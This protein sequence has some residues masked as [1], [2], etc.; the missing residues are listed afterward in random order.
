MTTDE[1][2]ESL[3]DRLRSVEFRDRLA[4]HEFE[5]RLELFGLL[6]GGFLVVVG[7]ATVAGTPWTHKAS[8]GAS[9][10]Q[11]VGA[12]GT[13]AVGAGLVWLTQTWTGR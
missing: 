3:P 8:L 4:D 9:I 13:A 1:A 10:L 2:K 5:D 7:L 6:A 12:L 11:V